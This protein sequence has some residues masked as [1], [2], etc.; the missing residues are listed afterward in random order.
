M[1]FD[2]Q[3]AV[4]ETDCDR[5]RVALLVQGLK[6]SAWSGADRQSLAALQNLS[7]R[8]PPVGD[9]RAGAGRL[10][11]QRPG[12]RRREQ[13]PSYNHRPENVAHTRQIAVRH[14]GS[15]RYGV[16]QLGPTVLVIAR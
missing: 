9:E 1:I 15:S 14:E 2:E 10:S 6:D 7:G 3:R 8:Q 11:G 16:V 5:E 12:Y 4:I 13:G